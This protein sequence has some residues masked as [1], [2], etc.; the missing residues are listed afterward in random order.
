MEPDNSPHVT[1][2]ALRELAERSGAEL[3]GNGELM[4]H[5]VA[6]LEDADA[7]SISFLSNNRYR[8]QLA[9]TRAGAVIVALRDA[10]ATPLP[11]LTTSTCCLGP[12]PT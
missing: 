10:D 11:K 4:I 2:I 12:R 5:R 7:K 8:T 1:G 9:A 6:T 3:A